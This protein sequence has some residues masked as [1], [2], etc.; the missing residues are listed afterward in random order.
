[1][2]G[3]IIKAFLWVWGKI[4][5]AIPIKLETSYPGLGDESSEEGLSGELGS[6]ILSVEVS[7]NSEQTITEVVSMENVSQI[8]GLIGITEFRRNKI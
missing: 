1:M 8:Q 3:I 2:P 4:K 7:M 6:A 5:K